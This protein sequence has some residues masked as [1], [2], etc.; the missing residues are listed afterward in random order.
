MILRLVNSILV[1][2]IVFCIH[3]VD[4]SAQ[5]E[6]WQRIA[7]VGE[8]FTVLMPTQAVEVSRLIPLNDSDSVPERVYYSL[9]DGKRYMVVSFTK[10]SPDRVAGLSSF[11]EFLRSIEQSFK[12]GEHEISKSLMFNREI[13]FAGGIA[14]QYQVKIGTYPG[15]AR[16]LGTEKAF[17]AL[18]VIGADESHADVLRFLSS[19][20]LGEANTITDSSSVVVNTVLTAITPSVDPKSSS[21]SLPPEPW[22]RTAGPIIGGVLNGKAI[23]LSVPEYPAAARKKHEAGTV[24]VYIIIDE[25]GNVIKA[26]A[27]DGPPNLREAAVAAAWK[28][29][30][31]PTRL[32]GQPVKVS[33]RIIYNFVAR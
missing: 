18:M 13:P 31:T 22:P 6:S 8:T 14:K 1:I 2:I 3:T 27:L 4:I 24:E 7:P 19:F 32:M 23:H 30:F 10:T 26:E 33:G 28:S 12:S 16:F 17:Y 21:A 15:V 20:A 29:R 9:A 11:D 25:L 5:E